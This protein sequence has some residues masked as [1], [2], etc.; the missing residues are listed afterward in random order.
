MLI[1]KKTADIDFLQFKSILQYLHMSLP[2]NFLF[3]EVIFILTHCI[4]L[5]KFFS[6]LISISQ[7]I[8]ELIM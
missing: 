3:L 8:K 4:N 5:E 6:S 1:E 2:L 7:Y